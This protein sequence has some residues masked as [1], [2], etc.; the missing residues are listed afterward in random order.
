M[1]QCKYGNEATRAKASARTTRRHDAKQC[2]CY[3][4]HEASN[5]KN[6]TTAPTGESETHNPDGSSNYTRFSEQ[7]WGHDDYRAFIASKGQDP[8]KVTFSW[9]WTSN[10]TGSGFWNKLNNVRPIA[11]D[12]SRTVDYEA[13]ADSVRQ[14]ELVPTERGTEPTTYVVGLADFQL[15]KGEGDG[16]PGTVRRI[17]ASLANIVE[18]IIHLRDRGRLPRAVLLA[19]MGDHTEGVH[20]SYA[21]QS[22]T[23]D[24]NVRD[25]INLALEINLLWIKTL[26]PYFE[27]V[28]Y[29]ACLCNHGQL[30]RVGG[31][32]NVSD[33]A[34][35][36]TGLIGDT[37]KTLCALHPDLAHVKFVIP[38]DEM[39]TTV[40]VSGVNVA[41]AHGHKISGAEPAWLAKQSANLVHRKKFIVDLWFTAHKHH[42]SLVDLGPY[43]RIQATTSDPGSKYF[44]DMSGQYSRSGITVFI[45]GK[46]IPGN[47]EHY[48]VL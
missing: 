40:N 34:D 38:Q 2:V 27:E 10:A 3:K 42:A 13:L 28:I 24:L 26:A 16:T 43:T 8:D 44:E 31:K 36:A 17:K 22:Y 6:A 37:L 33:D 41:M 32:T 23:A 39:I 46:E 7:P 18:D 15:G 19:N 30:S 14:M 4:E 25:Q 47:W 1:P 5:S 45:T 12:P 20:S 11:D 9:G 29:S 21:N 35:N 48:R